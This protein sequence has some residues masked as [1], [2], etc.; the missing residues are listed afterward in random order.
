[1]INRIII[2]FYFLTGLSLVSCST[3]ESI[4]IE[5]M[6]IIYSENPSINL[7]AKRSDWEKIDKPVYIEKRKLSLNNYTHVWIKGEFTITE[8][9]TQYTGIYLRNDIMT[10]I[11]YLNNHFIGQKVCKKII[12]LSKPSFYAINSP[13]FKKGKNTILVYTGIPPLMYVNFSSHIQILPETES[14]S[15]QF[16]NNFLY[17][18]GLIGMIIIFFCFIVMELI[19]FFIDKRT[20]TRLIFLSGLLYCMALLSILFLK[21]EKI[22]LTI[23]VT[24][25]FSCIPL[26][27]LYVLYVIQ[28]LYGIFLSYINRLAVAT[29]LLF[30]LLFYF[31]AG[32]FIIQTI[33]LSLSVI[34]FIG[35]LIYLLYKLHQVK[36]NNTLLGLIVTGICM[37]IVSLFFQ[38]FIPFFDFYYP[39]FANMYQFLF[40]LLAAIIYEAFDSRKK[41]LKINKLYKQLNTSKIQSDKTVT[42]TDSSREKLDSV[43]SFMKENF[44][45]DLSREGLAAAIDMN[46]NYFSSL[47]NEY[48]GKKINEFINSLRIEDASAK[49]IESDDSI[50]DI[51]FSTGFENLAT[52][53]RVFKSEKGMTPSKYREKY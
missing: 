50:I 37:T 21:L 22:N 33:A 17:Y 5:N 43:I 25:F 10:D 4:L 13:V 47:F 2:V 1:M 3:D 18:Y 19:N 20:R 53:N 31:I 11:V 49:L 12:D 45:S 24:F 41:R 44:T 29:V 8:D 30:S 15:L 48:T 51:A 46:P 28:A 6:E 27:L 35:Y 36:S 32:K 16:R 42:I 23:L 38:I 7:I 52:F 26:Q 39:R 9:P 40:F 14:K 34:I